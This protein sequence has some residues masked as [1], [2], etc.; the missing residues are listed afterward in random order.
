MNFAKATPGPWVSVDGGNT[1]I[2]RSQSLAQKRTYGYGCD[3]TFI[4]SLQDGE[5]HNYS[6]E[7][8][9]QASA[10]L[11]AS[12]PNLYFALL[13][14]EWVDELDESGCPKNKICPC[15]GNF[16]EY[17]HSI[18]CQLKAALQRAEGF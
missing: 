6:N 18:D 8:E 16:Q 14:V 12:A 5:Y 11:I 2:S 9:K 1:I 13:S 4:C 17:G 3:E 7:E 10:A 15:C